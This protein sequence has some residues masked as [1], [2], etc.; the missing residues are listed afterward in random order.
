M[1]LSDTKEIRSLIGA[2][3]SSGGRNTARSLE[4]ATV[5]AYAAY[6]I[7]SAKVIIDGLPRYKNDGKQFI[8]SR[9]ACWI[10]IAPGMVAMDDPVYFKDTGWSTDRLTNTCHRDFYATRAEAIIASHQKA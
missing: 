6:T 8:P 5:A 3:R 10:I 1:N 4:L 9:D 2:V 7:E